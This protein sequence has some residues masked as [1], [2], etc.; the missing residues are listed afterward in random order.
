MAEAASLF[1]LFGNFPPNWPGE[2][3]KPNTGVGPAVDKDAWLAAVNDAIK[4]KDIRA[5][6]GTGQVVLQ[7]R[8]WV[9]LTSSAYLEGLPLVFASMPDVEFRVLALPESKAGYVFA[10]QSDAGVEVLIEGLPVEI[11]LPPGLV[12]LHPDDE[13][14]TPPHEK[15]VGTFSAGSLDSQQIVYRRDGASSV[16]THVRVRITTD[17]DVV[18]ATPVPISFGK[19]RFLDVPALAV[20][21]FRLIPFPHIAQDSEEWLRHAIGPW[22]GSPDS[23]FAGC[24]ATRGL[25]LDP[26]HPPISDVLEWASGHA[27]RAEVAHFVLDDLVVPFFSP[28]VLPVPRH[29]TVGIRRNLTNPLD[30]NA[31]YDFEE[32]PIQLQFGRD[33]AWGMIVEEFF[34][35]SQPPEAIGDTLNLGI[36]FAAAIYF[37]DIN[38]PNNAITLGLG[39][40]LT[41]RIGYRRE[42]DVNTGV[43]LDDGTAFSILKF[44]LLG[45]T[46]EIMG[47]TVGYSIGRAVGEGAS[48]GDSAELYGDLFISSEP[49]GENDAFFK[50]R[51]LSGQPVRF[52]IEGLGWRQGSFHLEGVSAPD[53]VILMFGPVG[54]IFQELGM[55]AEDGASFVSFSGGLMVE[56]PG[57]MSG[58]V[59]VKR[60]RFR[61]AGNP[62]APV[63]KLDGIFAFFRAPTVYIEAGGYFADETVEGV[64]RKEFGFTGTVVF[65]VSGI[66]YGLSIDLL[67][68]EIEGPAEEFFYLMLQA[69][70][71]GLIPVYAVEIRGIRLLFADDMQPKLSPLDETFAQTRYYSWYKSNDPVRVP[72]NR[73]LAAWKPQN[74]AWAF[75]VGATLSITGLGNVGRLTM[76]VMGLDSPTEGGLLV[77]LELY[78]LTA[79]KPSAYAVVEVDLENDRYAVL[80]GVDLKISDFIDDLPDWLNV[81]T[82][83]GD[84][85]FGNKPGTVA[86]GRIKD[87]RT[88]L[89]L[90]WDLDIWVFR[91]YLQVGLCFEWVDGGD[92]GIGFVVRMEGSLSA[93][94]IR[95]SYHA[96]IGIVYISF[97]TGSVDQALA[98][99]IEAGVRAVLF[100]FLRFGLSVGADFKWVVRG[101]SRTEF[102]AEIRFETPWFMPDVT[103][104]LEHSSGTVVPSSLATFTA[105]LQAGS[106]HQPLTGSS[107]QLRGGAGFALHQERWDTPAFDPQTGEELPRDTHSIADFRSSA[108]AEGPR[109]ARFLANDTIQPIPID[110][111]IAIE[112][113]ALVEDALGLGPVSANQGQ[114]TSGDLEIR[115]ELIVLRI[116]RR[117]RFDDTGTWTL[118]ENRVELSVDFDAPGGPTLAGSFGPHEITKF[119]AADLR[120]AGG[121]ATKKL[122]LNSAT[123]YDF[124][125]ENPEVDESVVRENGDWPCCPVSDDKGGGWKVH[126]LDFRSEIPGNDITAFRTFSDSS[127]RW[128]ASRA[129]VARPHLFGTLPAGIVVAGTEGLL[130]GT[131]YRADLDRAAIYCSARLAWFGHVN[132]E[133]HLVAYEGDEEVGRTVVNATGS[134]DYHTM[135]VMG[136]KPFRSFELQ[137]VMAMPSRTTSETVPAPLGT[138]TGEV[139]ATGLGPGLEVEAD[140]FTYIDWQEYLRVVRDAVHCDPA[141]DDFKA[142]WEAKGK[143]FFLPNRQYE[144]ETTVRI[145]AGHPSV[146]TELAEVREYLYFETKGLPGLNAQQRVGQEV[147]PYVR[148]VYTGG[149][150]R[151]YRE[152]LVAVAFQEDFHVAVPLAL[153]P[154]GAIDE[155]HQLFRMALTTRPDAAAEGD[156]VYTATSEDWIVA[157]R[158]VFHLDGT[159]VWTPVL[160]DSAMDVANARS[161]HPLRMRL[162]QITQRTG[163]SCPL[164][165]PVDVISPLL[166]ARPQGTPDPEDASAALWPADT[167]YR[168]MVRQDQAPFID[169]SLFVGADITAL[170]FLS[171]TGTSGGAGWTVAN[172]EVHLS[173]GTS[174]RYGCFGEENW[175]HLRVHLGVHAGTGTAGLAMALPA[176]GA[177]P[178]RGLYAVVRPRSGGGRELAVLR[179]LTGT[180]L[181][182]LATA[183]LSADEEW[184][185]LVVSAFDDKL[186]VESGDV[187]LEVDRG[188]LREGRFALVG[189]GSVRFRTLQAEGLDI[190]A[191]T[192]TTSHYRSFAQHIQSYDGQ[193]RALAPDALGPGSSTETVSALW[194]ATRSEIA[195][196]MQA[197]GTSQTRQTLFSHWIE[198]LALP[199]VQEV[200]HLHISR[201]TSG[202]SIQGFLLESP[203]P[204]DFTEEVNVTLRQRVRV[205]GGDVSVVLPE[206]ATLL[207]RAWE[208]KL[209]LSDL[210]V[211]PGEPTASPGPHHPRLGSQIAA[212][213]DPRNL[214][215][216]LTAASDKTTF[217][218]LPPSETGV[219]ATRVA[220]RLADGAMAATSTATGLHIQ[221]NEQS[222]GRGPVGLRVGDRVEVMELMSV[223]EGEELRLKRWAGTAERRGGGALAVDAT[224][225]STTIVPGS[226]VALAPSELNLLDG[227][228]VAIDPARGRIIDL[229]IPRWEWQEVALGVLQDETAL[230]ALLIP[231]SSA[232]DVRSLSARYYQLRFDLDRKRWSTTDPP[233]DDNRYK[234][235]VLLSLQVPGL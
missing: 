146:E 9:N 34:Y 97:T 165:D 192:F 207:E 33:P 65:K 188:E 74:E 73:R 198:G 113:T 211:A 84:L 180:E 137:L 90:I 204:I 71:R 123:P 149:H 81:L 99:F 142:A 117:P 20:H 28:W 43:L 136:S 229:L 182:S 86:L 50:L 145:S 98:A 92:W 16:R 49:F 195:G 23:P 58:G 30:P 63:F 60:L 200:E 147:E 32:A 27:E 194:A 41:P 62:D 78:L 134:S 39:E 230:R 235:E 130:P 154:P 17:H 68:G 72:G 224:E 96:G 18:L 21:D 126:R 164:A 199:L 112:F 66:E 14:P 40:N 189:S 156:T 167:R 13:S 24:F 234:D 148:S 131:L 101:P 159:T 202:A 55:L 201:L 144:I 2:R 185:S 209:D 108:I 191:F 166:I 93:G 85:L 122:L 203:E 218:G 157:H 1:G 231:V 215:R 7:A 158:D 42:I 133:L 105:P 186:R 48:F 11:K 46:V 226:T 106:A 80:F 114:Q 29:I 181:V 87:Q 177:T 140:E 6:A 102:V 70:F 110:S 12:A 26:N 10:T 221:L 121:T 4:L 31:L 82:L 5:N 118:V 116:R 138:T 151:V 52:A 178:N 128:R 217:I 187:A 190:H 83:K 219:A 94:I 196:A 225:E 162:G 109:V 163:T 168:A 227:V 125:T 169:R 8:F 57:G 45:M 111:T 135:S 127:S 139:V 56:P 64:R 75:G 36:T 132:A 76:F 212:L 193:L 15:S 179:R 100:G 161:G 107:G 155:R 232:G 183:P 47:L 95:I 205:P 222:A 129:S 69:V 216:T 54:F 124:V 197:D 143:L 214:I 88:W 25:E 184:V 19:C 119:W 141:A 91:S 37:G 220:T 22:V 176:G 152:E 115:Y 208:E 153:R 175:N 79:K 67:T 171:D 103:F 210:G 3:F 213:L 89:S 223:A 61:V 172:G 104:R 38:E 53:G 120:T 44:E 59:T 160:A 35:Q 206:V 228:M 233:D 77:A 170:T 173:G 51:S 174:L 150:S